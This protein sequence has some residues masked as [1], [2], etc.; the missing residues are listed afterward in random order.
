MSFL[1]LSGLQY[2]YNKYI[3]NIPS[4]I[5]NLTKSI[6]NNAKYTPPEASNNKITNTLLISTSGNF[7]EEYMHPGYIAT[8]D[9]SE[10]SSSPVTSG[11]FYAYREVFFSPNKTI[12]KLTEAYPQNGRI[13]VNAYDSDTQKWRGWNTQVLKSDIANNL[14]TTDTSKVASATM[15]KKLNDEKQAK[16]ISGDKTNK[17]TQDLKNIKIIMS[18]YNGNGVVSGYDSYMVI[19]YACDIRDAQ[20]YYCFTVGYVSGNEYHPATVSNKV[21]SLA[22]N[23]V[24]TV[25]VQGGS[26]SFVKQ[27][28]ILIPQINFAL[29]N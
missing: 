12:V 13:W 14:T 3:K 28:F 18:D 8:E 5:N 10:L 4:K 22:T 1:N 17:C 25:A 2:F 9:A 15:V 29:L 6:D 24:G 27:V 20:Q 21:L 16:T 7:S 11:P 26:S 19:H 23:S